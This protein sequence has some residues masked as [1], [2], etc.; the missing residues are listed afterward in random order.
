MEEFPKENTEQGGEN[1][2]SPEMQ[3]LAD[4]A[5]KMGE[6]TEV[7]TEQVENTEKEPIAEK[8]YEQAREE[9]ARWIERAKEKVKR[10]EEIAPEDIKIVTNPHLYF[11]SG[12]KE[13]W[14]LI[15]IDNEQDMQTFTEYKD[16]EIK[17]AQEQLKEDSEVDLDRIA[18]S[19]W[20]TERIGK[21]D[22]KLKNGEEFTEEE[23]KYIEVPKSFDE[24]FHPYPFFDSTKYETLKNLDALLHGSG[25]FVDDGGTYEDILRVGYTRTPLAMAR[26]RELAKKD[27]L[28]LHNDEGIQDLLEN[29]EERREANPFA[30]ETNI[31]SETGEARTFTP[32]DNYPRLEGESDE[33]W[34][35]RLKRIQLKTRLAE[36]RQEQE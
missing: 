17:K 12:E 22:E 9:R 30:G 24:V 25:V 2:L 10:A 26:V 4:M 14:K 28:A 13:G 7:E 35:N 15:D 27:R 5:G 20:N 16:R 34:A 1:N 3:E 23:L 36:K 32:E 31:N 19:C 11:S 29:M 21:I 8:Y 6:K 33:D 18:K